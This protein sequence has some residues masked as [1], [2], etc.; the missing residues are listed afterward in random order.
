MEFWPLQTARLTVGL[1]ATA[2]T[3]WP[4][5]PAAGLTPKGTDSM[6][7]SRTPAAS[8]AASLTAAI[9]PHSTAFGS[10]VGPPV[11]VIDN[12]AIDAS[13]LSSGMRAMSLLDSGFP[14]PM[15]GTPR[16]VDP[17]VLV[18]WMFAQLKIESSSHGCKLICGRSGSCHGKCMKHSCRKHATAMDLSQPKKN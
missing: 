8:L 3:D 14:S 7:E 10:P 6:A 4:G 11:V 12:D 17:A 16:K 18:P 2:V 5:G 13:Q 9:R 15:H 1:A